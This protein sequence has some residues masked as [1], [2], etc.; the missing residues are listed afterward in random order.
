MWEV[1]SFRNLEVVARLLRGAIDLD[2]GNGAAFSELS[3]ALVAEGLW[4]LLSTSVAYPAAEVALKKALEIDPFQLDAKTATACLKLVSERDWRGASVGF[5]EVL[6]Q[7]PEYC[8]ALVGRA[9]L[10]V[11]EEHLKEASSLLQKAAEQN[12]LSSFAAALY[13]WTE[14]LSGRWSN[15]LDHVSQYRA[16]GRT[17]PVVDAVEALVLI[18]LEDPKID[19]ER[20][21]TMAANSP[22]H[23]V[24]QG[25][26]GCAYAVTGHCEKA[27]E[28][29]DALTNPRRRWRNR[30]PY[31]VALILVGLNERQKAVQWL[32]QSYRQGSLWSLG[33]LSDPI[34]DDLRNDPHFRLFLSK[35]SYPASICTL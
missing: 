29:L 17:G 33:F 2:P 15:V 31:A 7:Q 3:L 25:A 10:H 18:Q 26:L 22:E 5:D 1:L 27:R 34:L 6:R 35:V 16:S 19:M 30:E 9:M 13:I 24:L 20:I 8:L 21:E 12:A 32:E 14:Y 28:I 4:G 11:A 23:S